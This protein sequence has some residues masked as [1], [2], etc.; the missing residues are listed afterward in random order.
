MIDALDKTKTIK[1]RLY[2]ESCLNIDGF[3]I[4]DLSKLRR[5]IDQVILIDNAPSSYLLH[6]ENGVAVKSWFSDPDD[7]ELIG[8]LK[9]ALEDLVRFPDVYAWKQ[10]WEHSIHHL[11]KSDS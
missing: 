8:R 5:P 11:L 2:R 3:Y 10:E 9:P 6:P 4:K 7:D 1:H